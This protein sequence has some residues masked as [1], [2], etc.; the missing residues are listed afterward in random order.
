[1]EVA[2]VFLLASSIT[3]GVVGIVFEEPVADAKT[4]G[5]FLALGQ[6]EA[7]RSKV[8]DCNELVPSLKA[9]F[10]DAFRA[11]QREV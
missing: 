5:E 1:M 7:A 4:V 11:Y 3:F 9:E 8:L 6:V 2:R 10:D